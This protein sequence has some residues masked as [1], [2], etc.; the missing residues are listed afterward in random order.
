VNP[1]DWNTTLTASADHIELV[2][3]GR[4][5]VRIAVADITALSYGQKAYRHFA[6][7]AALSVIAT[8][9]ALFGILH[10]ST[11]HLVG[12]EF[13]T[14]AGHCAVLLMVDKDSYRGLLTTLKAVTGKPV[15]YRP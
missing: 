1:F 12:I 13:K 10:K 7:M 15:E 2:F 9:I 4:K 14:P 6:N 5:T 11:D 3:G 8:P